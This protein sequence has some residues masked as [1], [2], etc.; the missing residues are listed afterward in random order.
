M[1]SWG[2][3][4]LTAAN[5]AQLCALR[6]FFRQ[7]FEL[8]FPKLAVCQ[9]EKFQLS[10]C[11]AHSIKAKAIPLCCSGTIKNWDESETKE[12]ILVLYIL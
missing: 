10:H 8:A 3:L 1:Q 2:A 11:I 9:H 5:T 6:G 7:M 12:L 4:G